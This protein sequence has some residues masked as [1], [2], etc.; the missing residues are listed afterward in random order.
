MTKEEI[1]RTSGTI[2]VAGSE[3]TASLM[4]GA[5]FHLL[6][7]PSTMERLVSEIRAAFANAA[8]MTFLKLAQLKY[9][10]ACIQEAFRMYPPVPGILPRKT[11]RE[12]VVISGRFI[13]GNV[14]FHS[15]F[16]VFLHCSKVYLP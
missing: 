2:I 9:F 6:S 10:N 11:P 16:K 1:M 12:G 15:N 5:L 8:D 14:S 7:N 3:T 13:P 4:S